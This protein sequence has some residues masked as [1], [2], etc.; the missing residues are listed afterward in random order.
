MTPD[1]M[2]LSSVQ[3]KSRSIVKTLRN[4]NSFKGKVSDIFL[5]SQGMY[6]GVRWKEPRLLNKNSSIRFSVCIPFNIFYK[7]KNPLFFVLL[8][9]STHNLHPMRHR[10]LSFLFSTCLFFIK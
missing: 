2:W 4:E 10:Y 9:G 8:C 3:C 1:W 5:Y 6:F 7:Y